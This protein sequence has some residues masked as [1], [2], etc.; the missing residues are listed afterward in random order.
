MQRLVFWGLAFFLSACNSLGSGVEALTA[1]DLGKEGLPKFSVRGNADKAVSSLKHDEQYVIK[2]GDKLS[3]KFFFN[4]ELN[5]EELIVRPDGRISLQLIHEVD[6]ANLTATQLRDQLK[7][8]YAGQ[9]KTPEIAVIVR[10]VK[11]PPIVYVSGEVERPGEFEIIGSLS[12]LQAT[13][14]AGGIIE[15]TAKK[16]EV[17]VMRKDPSGQTFI[18]KLDLT[19][20][21]NGTDLTQNIRL[22]PYDFVHVPRSFW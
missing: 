12:V 1:S 19:A 20:A 21:L 10:S 18:I 14:R 17:I 13:S 9:V 16:D 2:P 3:I 4:P 8:R 6:A 7:D 22:R 5:E 11:E 15:D